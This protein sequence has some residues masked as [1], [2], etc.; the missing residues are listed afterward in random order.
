[1]KKPKFA[2]LLKEDDDRNF[3]S[4]NIN[5]MEYQEFNKGVDET[6]SK[7]YSKKHNTEGYVTKVFY[8]PISK[9]F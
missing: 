1:M 2:D 4:I 7:M 6:P 9:F 3:F 8:K 5:M